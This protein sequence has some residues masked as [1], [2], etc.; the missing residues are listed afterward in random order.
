VGNARV[1]RAGFTVERAGEGAATSFVYLGKNR[2]E[3][4]RSGTVMTLMH[5]RFDGEA[6]V[7]DVVDAV[8]ELAEP[9]VL[10]TIEISYRAGDPYETVTVRSRT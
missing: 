6:R 3:L 9:G 8:W 10:D 2:I 4:E 5:F 1:T 7:N